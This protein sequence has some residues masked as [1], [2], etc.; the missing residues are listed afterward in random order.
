MK[1][2]KALF[3]IATLLL[4]SIQSSL[5]AQTS[6]TLDYLVLNSG[7][8]LYGNVE[9]MDQIDVSPKYYKK[10]RIRDTDPKKKKYKRECIS[11]FRTNSTNYEGFCISKSTRNIISFTRITN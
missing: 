10:I 5:V 4:L 3:I 7:V 1:I 11:A 8:T 2:I 9:H 6:S